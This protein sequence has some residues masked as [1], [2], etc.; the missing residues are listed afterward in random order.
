[1]HLDCELALQLGQN[2]KKNSVIYS[3]LPDLRLVLD[4]HGGDARRT[5]AMAA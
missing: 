3:A 1:M 4:G 2:A 5:T